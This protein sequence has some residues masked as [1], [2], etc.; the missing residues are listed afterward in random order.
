MR[1]LAI[2]IALAA[3]TMLGVSATVSAGSA[4]AKKS[5]AHDGPACATMST[6]DCAACPSGGNCLTPGACP[7][8]SSC[9]GSCS[10]ADAAKRAR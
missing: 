5:A 2:A 9:C 7:A 1:I 8:G 6:A 10:S 3:I 4:A